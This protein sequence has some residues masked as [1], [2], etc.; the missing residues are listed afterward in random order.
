[1]K[2]FNK[3]TRIT[4][5]ILLIVFGGIF[6]W[7]IVRGLMIQQKVAE[8]QPIP[9]VS[10]TKAKSS[11]WQPSLYAIG[12]L[13][14]VNGV[15]ISTQAAG[16]VV[17]INFQSGQHV[18][19]DDLIIQI[20]DRQEQAQLQNNTATLKLAQ[21]TYE[22]N[23]TLVQKNVIAKQTFDETEARYQQ[24][25]ADVAQTQAI[26]NYKHITAPFDG[27]IG[28]REVNLGQY[29][30]AGDPIVSL[31]SMDPLYVNFFLPEQHLRELSV[32][33]KV[34]L[35]VDSMPKIK[36][37]GKINALNSL[38]DTQTHNIAIQATVP[39]RNEQLYPGLFARIN[40]IL[41]K[42]MNVVIVPATAINYTL[43]GNSIF[44]L[45]REKIK[46][47]ENLTIELRDVKTGEQRN[48]EIIITGGIK[49]GEEI[50]TSGQLKL[51]NGQKVI[52]NNNVQLSKG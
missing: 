20:D 35:K 16:N 3:Q 41:P 19:K 28:I 30:R 27:K 21:V 29:L 1:M 36:F 31:Q 11:T 13:T 23:K 22:R 50:V 39:N 8:N 34:T 48:D 6:A 10:V 18:K 45:K 42:K 33:Q 32:G 46:D 40:V 12:T 5:L 14:A 52:I 15:S 24:A 51:N 17:Q 49:A 9:A 7:N 2:G 26:I 25:L 47:Q 44:V 43:Y 4:L 38:V 37:E